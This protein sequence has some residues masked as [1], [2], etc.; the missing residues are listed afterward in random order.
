[1]TS[2]HVAGWSCTPRD[3]DPGRPG[4]PEF[5]RRLY[6]LSLP[7]SA[8]LMVIAG[9]GIGQYSRWRPSHAERHQES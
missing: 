4:A 9:E 6:H 5:G 2:L 1:V 7:K 3:I 8:R